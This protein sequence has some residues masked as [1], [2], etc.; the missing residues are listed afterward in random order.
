MEQRPLASLSS[1]VRLTAR[2]QVVV[3]FCEHVHVFRDYER[4][5]VPDADAP[6]GVRYRLNDLDV[7][8]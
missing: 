7:Q 2:P 1:D 5:Y 8:A 3:W 4:L 6:V